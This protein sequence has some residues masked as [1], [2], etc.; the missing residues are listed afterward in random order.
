MAERLDLMVELATLGEYGLTA[1][2]RPLATCPEAAEPV[3]PATRLRERCDATP[4]AR[5]CR[6]GASTLS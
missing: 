3:R 6:D 5:S 1:D 4:A 2:L